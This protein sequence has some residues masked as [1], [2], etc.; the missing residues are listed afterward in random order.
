MS[1]SGATPRRIVNLPK[2]ERFCRRYGDACQTRSPDDVCRFGSHLAR[3]PRDA[4]T[5]PEPCRRGLGRPG[6]TSGLSGTYRQPGT[7]CSRPARPA[8]PYLPTSA[9]SR[10]PVSS[11][12]TRSSRSWRRESSAR[13][14][15]T[16]R[17]RVCERMFDIAELM[18]SAGQTYLAP[19]PADVTIEP[20]RGDIVDRTFDASTVG[21]TASKLVF[22]SLQGE[23]SNVQQDGTTILRFVPS[24]PVASPS[25]DA[26]GVPGHTPSP[27]DWTFFSGFRDD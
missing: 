24:A 2:R 17:P 1:S 11:T 26:E 3:F 7:T 16:P 21:E 22:Q 5:G 20:P 13:L 15:L 4:L 10:L 18:P 19:L 12:T 8:N 27:H 6:P 14:V 9:V 25:P 23:A